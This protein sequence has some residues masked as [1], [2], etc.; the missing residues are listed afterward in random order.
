ML[1]ESSVFITRLNPS[2]LACIFDLCPFTDVHIPGSPFRMIMAGKELVQGM[3]GTS[4]IKVVL[5]SFQ[6]LVSL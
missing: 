4:A 5:H 1:F 6:F 2:T 3:P